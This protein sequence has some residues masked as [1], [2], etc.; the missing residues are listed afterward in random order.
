MQGA[1]SVRGVAPGRVSGGIPNR[2]SPRRP[3]AESSRAGPVEF[4]V[5]VPD[6][7][8]PLRF[9]IAPSSSLP[10]R[11]R[12]PDRAPGRAEVPVS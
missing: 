5:P 3:R 6:P 1:A 8:S 10:F 2:L 9:A 7:A 4:A 11:L 12:R